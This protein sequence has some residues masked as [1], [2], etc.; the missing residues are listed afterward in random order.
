M[1]SGLRLERVDGTLGGIIWIFNHLD[2]SIGRVCFVRTCNA[3]S[4]CTTF[5]RFV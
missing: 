4:C 1:A 2:G 3:M 5:H